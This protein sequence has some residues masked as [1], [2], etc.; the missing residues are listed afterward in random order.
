MRLINQLSGL[1]STKDI[2]FL[3]RLNN[4]L[5]GL[6]IIKKIELQKKVAALLCS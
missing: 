3:M 5:S 6:R 4:K 1:I 2:G